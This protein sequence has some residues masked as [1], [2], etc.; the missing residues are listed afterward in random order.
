VVVV[1]SVSRPLPSDAVHVSFDV[2]VAAETD[3]AVVSTHPFPSLPSLSHPVDG[4]HDLESDHDYDSTMTLMRKSLL[5]E[6]EQEECL[7]KETKDRRF[8]LWMNLFE[9][10]REC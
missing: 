7:Q 4:K 9:Q 3:T 10:R 5:G 8:L 1:D 6:E 2:V